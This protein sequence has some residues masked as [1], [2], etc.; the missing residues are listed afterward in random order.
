MPDVLTIHADVTDFP[1]PDIRLGRKLLFTKDINKEVREILSLVK[2]FAVHAQPPTEPSASLLSYS[3]VTEGT[4]PEHHHSPDDTMATKAL[5]FVVLF[6]SAA[7]ILAQNC[8][9]AGGLCCSQWGYCGTGN[10]YCGSGCRQN[11]G[12]SSSSS[13]GGSSSGGGGGGNGVITKDQL[14]RVMENNLPYDYIN[15]LND[16][17]KKYNLNTP[18]RMAGFLA[19]VRHETA[20]LTTFYQPI[21]G[22]AGAIHMLPANFRIACED[23][24]EIKSAFTKKFGSCRGGSDRD[25]GALLGN[26]RLAFLTGAWWMAEGSRKILGGPCGDLRPVLDQGL[27]SQNPLSGYYLVSRCIFGGSYDAGLAQR[28]KYYNTAKKVFNV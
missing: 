7:L 9:C 23:V 20:G 18:K 15:D 10:D 16:V 17:L 26:P 8:G 4:N 11:C 14:R 6:S 1:P 24:A 2:R 19:Q 13:S 28:V 3:Y 27:G 21:D 12:S 25:A 5:L 22:G